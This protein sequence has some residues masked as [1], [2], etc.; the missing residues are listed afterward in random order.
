MLI[1][2]NRKRN[3]DG[4]IQMSVSEFNGLKRIRRHLLARLVDFKERAA[5]NP[6]YN[7]RYVRRFKTCHTDLSI[8]DNIYNLVGSPLNLT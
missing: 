5:N 6:R 8:V 3:E 4:H 1:M 2:L 7:T